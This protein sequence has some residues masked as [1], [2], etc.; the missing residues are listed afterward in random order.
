MVSEQLSTPSDLSDAPEHLP[1]GTIRHT[2]LARR[3]SNCKTCREEWTGKTASQDGIAHAARTGHIV[4]TKE[5][6]VSFYL[7]AK[8]PPDS[9]ANVVKRITAAADLDTLRALFTEAQVLDALQVTVGTD[10][11]ALTLERILHL[12]ADELKKV[13]GAT[14]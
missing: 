2:H 3:S 11:G 13:A 4:E 7:N 12:K 14:R 5:S 8:R 6:C 9:I 10:T 1:N